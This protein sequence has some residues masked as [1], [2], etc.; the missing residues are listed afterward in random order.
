MGKSFLS[1]SELLK[2]FPTI[3]TLI[4]ASAGHATSDWGLRQKE[5]LVNFG[6]N[7][8]GWIMQV[9]LD[10]LLDQVSRRFGICQLESVIVFY[11]IAHEVESDTYI[12]EC[13]IHQL[14]SIEDYV[15]AVSVTD[16]PEYTSR[17][18]S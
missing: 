2:I 4:S 1:G 12:L 14:N 8:E 11:G 3:Q 9:P 7:E 17:L 10:K 6:P 13:S 15:L 16:M 5:S 18:Q